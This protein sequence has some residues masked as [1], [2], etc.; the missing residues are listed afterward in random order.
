MN[1]R[2]FKPVSRVNLN[3]LSYLV[4]K[5]L[6]DVVVGL[7]RSNEVAGHEAGSLVN[8]LVEGV[9]PVGAGLAPDNGP[10]G[11]VNLGTR[12]GDIPKKRSYYER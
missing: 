8:E 12:A 11:V 10:G 4:V 5:T 1:T 3:R 2:L 9:L 6:P 7:G